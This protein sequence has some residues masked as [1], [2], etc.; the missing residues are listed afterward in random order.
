MEL[1]MENELKA[2]LKQGKE[3]LAKIE[4]ALYKPK[5]KGVIARPGTRVLCGSSPKMVI[6]KKMWERAYS[7]ATLG[8]E[9]IPIIGGDVY[10]YSYEKGILTDE[11]SGLPVIGYED[12]E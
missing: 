5:P 8:S 12:D 10:V 6:T 1:L 3:L 11:R 4:D 9:R 7:P 2:L